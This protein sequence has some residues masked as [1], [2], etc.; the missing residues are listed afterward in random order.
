MKNRHEHRRHY[1]LSVVVLA[2]LA[3]M[4]VAATPGARAQ[5]APQE[6][7]LI[8]SSTVVGGVSSVEAQEAAA[9]GFQV[10]IV[11]PPTWATMTRAQFSSYRA[12][13]LGDPDGP[14]SSIAAAEAN[15]DVWGPAINGN[16]IIIGSDPAGHAWQG[17]ETLIR[18]G[19]DFALDQAGKTGL[20]L[21]LSEYYDGAAAGT[22]VPV[23]DGI[24][25]GG[26]TVFGASCYDNAHI[27]AQHPALLGLNDSMLSNWGCSVH[28]AFD[29][30][31]ADFQV[32]AIAKDLNSSY[33]ASDGTQGAPYILASGSGLRSFPLS[34]TPTSANALAGT[35]H[36]VTA[37]LLDAGTG[38]AV[39]GQRIGFRVTSGPNAGVTGTC[40]VDVSCR[41]DAN[42]RISWS[43]RSDGRVGEDAIQAFV[44]SNGNGSPDVGEPQTTGRVL[45]NLVL[46]DPTSKKA[47]KTNLGNDRCDEGEI[48]VWS[49]Y[50]YTGCFYDFTPKRKDEDVDYSDGTPRW[51][52][53]TRTMNDDISSYW[54]RTSTHSVIFY[55][56]P[57]LREDNFCGWPGARSPDLRNHDNILSP[58]IHAND[59][60]SSH[61]TIRG[62]T[63]SSIFLIR[64]PK[65]WWDDV[66]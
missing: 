12:I 18:K 24:R 30:W 15:K 51:T 61:T 14:P 46:A 53:C 59:A 48:C 54:N 66:D 9:K 39:S 52:N 37:E 22:P 64:N 26:F 65:C 8:L 11:D 44:D 60:L 50:D 4:L 45:W 16:V 21:S 2:L 49:D 57:G 20:F 10:D 36:T 5:V 28:E 62:R 47:K 38:S 35:T 13:I 1:A 31:P 33:T 3:S 19:V 41:T 56:D 29:K 25:L 6:K 27:V 42:G 7:V 32:L 23:L 34:L 55:T 58:T 43:Y 63:D 17:G 40:N